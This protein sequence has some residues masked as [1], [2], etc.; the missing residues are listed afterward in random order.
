MTT[1][2]DTPVS[3][4]SVRTGAQ[5]TNY[6]TFFNKKQAKEYFQT[7]NEADLC[8][9]NEIYGSFR[10]KGS[11]SVAD[12]NVRVRTWVAGF[13]AC[14]KC[15]AVCGIHDDTEPLRIL[16]IKASE[17]L[18]FDNEAQKIKLQKRKWNPD[19]MKNHECPNIPEHASSQD[20]E[21]GN[22]VGYTPTASTVRSK[23]WFRLPQYGH[24][25][26][27]LQ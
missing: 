15:G 4:Q 24:F 10:M 21:T 18:K 5:E 13:W 3:S 2:C 26:R 22:N 23:I 17:N 8:Y 12:N 7:I 20:V 11:W 27:F 1:T 16:R 14:E 25:S 19:L 6:I 9:Q